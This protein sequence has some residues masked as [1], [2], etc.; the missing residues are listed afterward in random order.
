VCLT[1][2]QV[3]GTMEDIANVPLRVFPEY[4][5]LVIDI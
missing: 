5:K 2:L 4:I 3:I 1:R